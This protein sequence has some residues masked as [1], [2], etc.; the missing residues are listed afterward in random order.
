MSYE[1][2]L[3]D[4]KE[5][6]G[7]KKL[8]DS[9]EV[10]DAIGRSREA[11]AMMRSRK[12]FPIAQKRGRKVVVSIY[13]L[14]EYIA[15]ESQPL[16]PSPAPAVKPAHTQ[17]AKAAGPDGRTRRPPSLAKALASFR[18]SINQQQSQIEF[19]NAVFASLEARELAALL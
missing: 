10:A 18:A 13:D 14:A 11:L 6:F 9:Q 5:Q 3:A 4:L 16:H 8:L 17:S 1:R 7:T 19:Q 12:Q 2:A 15:G